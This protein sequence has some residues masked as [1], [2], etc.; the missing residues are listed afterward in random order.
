MKKTIK[1]ILRESHNNGID[2]YMFFS[3]LEQMKDQI[4]ELLRMDRY[5]VDEILNDGHNWAA[6]HITT[7][8]DD[9][10]EVYNFLKRYNR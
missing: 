2:N 9:I 10:E 1:K 5:M 3:N 7:S 6:D 4:E 8:K